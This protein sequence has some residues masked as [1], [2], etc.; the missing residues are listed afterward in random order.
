MTQPTCADCPWCG[1]DNKCHHSANVEY[2]TKAVP[3]SW[4]NLHPNS[5][6]YEV[7][8]YEVGAIPQGWEPLH[9]F[10]LPRLDHRI[11]FCRHLIHA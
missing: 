7:A 9:M 4:C 10:A 8:S 2:Y 1:T 3:N 6:Q 5:A 11:V